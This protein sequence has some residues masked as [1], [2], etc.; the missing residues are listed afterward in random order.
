M[1]PDELRRLMVA[2]GVEN[3]N[4]LA[5]KLGKNRS[6]VSR[7]LSGKS[8]ITVDALAHLKDKLRKRP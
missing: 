4:Q 7:W 3:G 2:N 5:A 6:T 8:K 1:T